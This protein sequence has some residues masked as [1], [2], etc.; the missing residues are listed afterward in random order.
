[1]VKMRPDGSSEERVGSCLHSCFSWVGLT[2]GWSIMP[3]CPNAKSTQG[4]VDVGKGRCVGIW[5]IPSLS[6]RL[7]NSRTCCIKRRLLNHSECEGLTR[8][9]HWNFMNVWG[10]LPFSLLISCVDNAAASAWFG[11]HVWQVIKRWIQLVFSVWSCSFTACFPWLSRG[12]LLTYLFY[13]GVPIFSAGTRSCP[14]EQ[15]WW[16]P[17]M[18][19]GFKQ[20]WASPWLMIY[21]LALSSY[22][23]FQNLRAF[24]CKMGTQKLNLSAL[25]K[26]KWNNS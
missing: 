24:I 17:G 20:T 15:H 7:L 21:C 8:W 14:K 10:V 1:M 3:N 16:V 26:M 2:Q 22:I 11:C 25:R 18:C 13:L 9:H 5:P 6:R 19:C 12:H 23:I 4:E